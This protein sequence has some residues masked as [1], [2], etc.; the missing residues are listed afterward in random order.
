M[1][2]IRFDWISFFLAVTAS[3][4][5]VSVLYAGGSAGE[6]QAIKKVIWL[7]VGIIIMFSLRFVNYQ[8]YGTYSVIFYTVTAILL[9][10]TLV[11][12]IGY[13]VKGARSW[14]KLAG[15][16]FQPA[17][18]AKITLV[19]IL[20]KYLTLRE[21]E[22]SQSKELII[23]FLIMM[24]P[25]GL[26]ALQPDLGYSMMLLPLVF[27]MLFVGGANVILLLGLY[28][29][30]FC[31]VFFPMYMEYHKFIIIDDIYSAILPLNFKLADAIQ[32]L[33]FDSW[34]YVERSNLAVKAN[35]IPDKT[36]KWAIKTIT[37]PENIKQFQKVANDIM[38]HEPNIIRDFFR[39]QF[40]FIGTLATF[41]IV[42]LFSFALSMATAKKSLRIISNIFLICVFVFRF[43][44]YCT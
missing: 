14:L 10:I 35:F 20:S 13:K 7:I 16:G 24:L 29:I 25:M 18:F 37:Q 38:Q 19:F 33:N 1:V 31:A 9:I 41:T 39:S 3:L 5:G 15:F 8:I 34:Q 44:L 42:Y 4:I 2:N 43:G 30:G 32:I 36:V 27:L 21:K 12:F 22:I 26:I 23:P 6:A 28:V 40:I 11:P 17:E